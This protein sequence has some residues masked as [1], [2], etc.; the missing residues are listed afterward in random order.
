MI[1]ARLPS[2]TEG[3]MGNAVRLDLVNRNHC[4]ASSSGGRVARARCGVILHQQ[5]LVL[6]P[7]AGNP[8]GMVMS[9][10]ATAV[11]GL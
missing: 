8:L 3:M 1:Q 11:V 6:D 10:A 7:A 5:A 9:D 2:R 4:T